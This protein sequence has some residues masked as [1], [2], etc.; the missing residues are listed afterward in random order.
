VANFSV[1]TNILSPAGLDW[2]HLGLFARLSHPPSAGGGQPGQQ[3]HA[4]SCC[5]P[6]C[7]FSTALTVSLVLDR[8]LSIPG[9]EGTW[10]K[11]VPGI[12]E[13]LLGRSLGRESLNTHSP[14][15]SLMP[16]FTRHS[17]L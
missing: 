1:T 11:P 5:L 13:E 7:A 9:Q 2:K 4:R 16:Q 15:L 3:P 6:R 17:E 12:A 14:H 10:C 8:T